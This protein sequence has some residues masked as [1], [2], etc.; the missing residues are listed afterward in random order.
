[1]SKYSYMVILLT[2][3]LGCLN[4]SASI[5]FQFACTYMYVFSPVVGYS[6]WGGGGSGSRGEE[7][8]EYTP[9]LHN[10]T[11]TPIFYDGCKAPPYM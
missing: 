4:V 7:M 8:S 10:D 6:S 2:T 9:T 5:T 3:C 1:M 11:R